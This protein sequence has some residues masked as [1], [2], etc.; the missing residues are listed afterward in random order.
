MQTF[1]QYLQNRLAQAEIQRLAKDLVELNVDPVRFARFGFLEGYSFQKSLKLAL[2]ENAPM[3]QQPQ[4]QDGNM[5]QYINSA[6]QAIQGIMQTANNP[7]VS[8]MLQQAQKTIEQAKLAAQQQQKMQQQQQKMQQ[9]GQ[10]MQKP[11]QPMQNQ[12]P[13][14]QQP[15]QQQQ[16]R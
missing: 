9:P 3:Q 2:K 11:G 6:T 16:P 7:K 10:P 14:Q 5:D 12:Q 4:Q 1:N 13:A 8:Q 15:V